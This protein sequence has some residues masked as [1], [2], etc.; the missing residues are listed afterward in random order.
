MY[1]LGIF[2]VPGTSDRISFT[3][4]YLLEV[5]SESKG[6]CRPGFFGILV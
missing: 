5:A 1:K 6:I 3:V 4:E 2:K